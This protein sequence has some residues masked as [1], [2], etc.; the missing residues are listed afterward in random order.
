MLVEASC[1]KSSREASTCR[2]G[3]S[4][5][6]ERECKKTEFAGGWHPHDRTGAGPAAGLETLVIL[7]VGLP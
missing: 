6:S 7:V 5:C 3:M 2:H 1:P 4:V